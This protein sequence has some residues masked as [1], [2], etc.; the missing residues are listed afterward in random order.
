MALVDRLTAEC[1]RH[2]RLPANGGLT[3]AQL[4]DDMDRLFAMYDY[5]W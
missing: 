5:D 1:A 2:L 3:D 4:L